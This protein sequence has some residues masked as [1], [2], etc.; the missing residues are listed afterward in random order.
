MIQLTVTVLFYHVEIIVQ[1]LY[2][3]VQEKFHAPK[4]TDTYA[5]CIYMNVNRLLTGVEG[6][7]ILVVPETPVYNLL[8]YTHFCL[9]HLAA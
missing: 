8:V 3:S 9:S 1:P 6:I 7:L 5:V 2:I 4:N